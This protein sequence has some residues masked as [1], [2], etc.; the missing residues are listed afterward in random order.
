MTNT[1]VQTKMLMMML[2]PVAAGCLAV[3]AVGLADVG[4][5]VHSS[6]PRD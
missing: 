2:L 5:G 1:F 3:V 4:V 6:P